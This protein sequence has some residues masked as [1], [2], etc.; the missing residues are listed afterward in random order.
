MTTGTGVCQ[1]Y[2]FYYLV[3]VLFLVPWAM[4]IRSVYSHKEHTNDHTRNCLAMQ[5]LVM[6]CV[7]VMMLFEV[8]F[9][10]LKQF[11]DSIPTDRVTDE[12]KTAAN[13]KA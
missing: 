5:S 11:S 3:N 10:Q 4:A 6:M 9:V 1:I 13:K 7:S 8:S 2:P 12:F